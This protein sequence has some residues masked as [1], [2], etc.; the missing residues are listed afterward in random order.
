M[1]TAQPVATVFAVCLVVGAAVLSPLAATAA[2]ETKPVDQGPDEAADLPA[3]PS[4][5]DRLA[6]GTEATATPE[7]DN[8]VTRIEIHA[9]GSAT[10][11]LSV[12]TRLDSDADVEDYEAFQDRFRENRSRYLA[13]FRDRMRGVVDSAENAT[14]REMAAG[15]FSVSTR[16]QEVP[17]Q[18]GVVTYT[19]RWDGFAATDGESLVAGDVFQGEYFLAENDTLTFEAPPE[20]GVEAASP[21]PDE[22][23][24]RAVTWVGQTS[25]DD[26]RPRATFE[27]AP[28]STDEPATDGPTTGGAADDGDAEGSSSSLPLYLLAAVLVAGVAVAGYRLLGGG[29]ESGDADESG[30]ETSDDS[31]GSSLPPAADADHADAD[32]DGATGAAAASDTDPALLTDEDRVRRLLDRNGGRVRQA[33]IADEFDWSDSKTSR[34]VSTMADDGVVEKLRIG[35]ENVIDLVEDADSGADAGPDE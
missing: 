3:S 24:E 34:V 32:A 26:E 13:P 29:S 4:S 17:R 31:G 8:T 1:G 28:E 11:K 6:V 20:Y 33:A 15:N 35:R 12:R 21:P 10:W 16:I 27:P 7:T 2:A 9:N 30:G 19:F 18:W 25:F 5:V 23:T 14:G 22:E